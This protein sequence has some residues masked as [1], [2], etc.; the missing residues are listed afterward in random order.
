MVD[1]QCPS[2]NALLKE[3]EVNGFKMWKC[4]TENKF[5]DV[6]EG[7]TTEINEKWYKA[8]AGEKLEKEDKD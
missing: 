8:L 1:Y 2:C 7:K 4:D 3:L 6:D 5:F